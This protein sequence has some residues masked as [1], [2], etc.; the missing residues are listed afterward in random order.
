MHIV[1]LSEAQPLNP[2]TYPPP[3]KSENGLL[4][5]LS[6]QN[7]R[8]SLLCTMQN[9]LDQIVHKFCYLFTIWQSIYNFEI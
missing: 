6:R 3:K 2:L 7:A 9:K 4:Q 5:H 8:L 1:F